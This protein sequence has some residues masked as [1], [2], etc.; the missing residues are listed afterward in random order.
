MR[1]THT[2]RTGLRTLV[3]LA[4]LAALTGCTQGSDGT[5]GAAPATPRAS[6]SAPV[7]TAPLESSVR[8]YVKA[9]YAPDTDTAYALL[10]RRCRKEWS[11]EG[12]EALMDRAA[13]TAEQLGRTYT[14]QRLSVD[15]IQGDGAQVTYGVGEPKYDERTSWVRED[16]E[17]HNDLC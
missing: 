5:P 6:S 13:Q 17:W 7:D 3:A 15:R 12:L 8:A 10:S 4:A 16:G 2:T 1:T 14:L 9:Y 11:R